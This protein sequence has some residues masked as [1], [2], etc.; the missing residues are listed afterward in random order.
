MNATLEQRLRLVE[1]E[2]AIRRLILSYGPAADGGLSTLAASIWEEDGLYDWDAGR[3]PHHG[4]LAVDAMLQTDGHRHLIDNG[5]AHF[6]GPPMIHL[7]GDSATALTYSMVLRRDTDTGRFFL[8]RVSAARW[9]L[10]RFEGA[11]RVHRRTH[12]L[13]DDTGAGR[14]LFRSS[15]EELFGETVP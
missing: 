6:T 3:E 4:R 14:D 11:W 1:D 12:R 9:E 7:D 13:L 15:L 5:V 2:L 10:A 8:W